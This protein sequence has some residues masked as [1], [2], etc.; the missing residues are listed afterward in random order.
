MGIENIDLRASYE[1]KLEL[2]RPGLNT[3]S[4]TAGVGDSEEGFRQTAQP[5]YQPQT[6]V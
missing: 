5:P 3:S 2:G 6:V 4:A 1:Q